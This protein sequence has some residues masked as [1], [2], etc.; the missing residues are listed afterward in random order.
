M[1]K[2]ESIPAYVSRF[3]QLKLELEAVGKHLDDEMLRIK[4]IAPL[5]RDCRRF[6][7]MD[8]PVDIEEA[9][10]KAKGWARAEQFGK[11]DFSQLGL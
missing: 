6:M 10:T 7:G 1:L 11:G 4:F 8:E 9:Y 2:G 5:P 3:E